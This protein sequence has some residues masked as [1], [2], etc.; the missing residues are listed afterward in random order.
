MVSKTYVN[1]FSLD[2]QRFYMVF[3]FVLNAYTFPRTYNEVGVVN[4]CFF[5]V[6]I[7][8]CT[9]RHKYNVVNGPRRSIES[10]R[11]LRLACN[12]VMDMCELKRQLSIGSLAPNRHPVEK[13]EKYT[14]EKS[15]FRF[16]YFHFYLDQNDIKTFSVYFSRER[17]ARSK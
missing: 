9:K 17:K 6:S 1:T 10:S 14:F 2:H 13:I 15:V 3:L 4:D 16:K 12:E 7:I 8:W 5:S 11:Q